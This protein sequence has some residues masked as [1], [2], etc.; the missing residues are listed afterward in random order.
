MDTW[1]NASIP[2]DVVESSTGAG[3][4]HH[5]AIFK[6]TLPTGVTNDI[7]ISTARH[8]A[9]GEALLQLPKF[10]RLTRPWAAWMPYAAIM[11]SSGPLFLSLV[12]KDY[13]IRQPSLPSPT[14]QV[15]TES[16]LFPYISDLESASWH[17]ADAKALMWLGVRPWTW[18]M[19]GG[20]AVLLGL[21]FINYVLISAVRRLVR[22]GSVIVHRVKQAKLA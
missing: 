7:M 3:E 2:F 6:P 5:R 21:W 9:F 22:K 13:L 12:L 15:I 18:F 20:V 19:L 17:R 8:P 4:D 1:C 11:I 10:F 14:V 16:D